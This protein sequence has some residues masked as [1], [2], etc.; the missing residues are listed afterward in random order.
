ML[1]KL[2]FSLVLAVSPLVSV[3][4]QAYQSVSAY[5]YTDFDTF[6]TE[7]DYLKDF[8]YVVEYG[9]RYG[10]LIGEIYFI[11]YPGEIY[12]YYAFPLNYDIEFKIGEFVILEPF[13]SNDIYKFYNIAV[14]Y[15]GERLVNVQFFNYIGNETEFYVLGLTSLS[16]SQV[17][18]NDYTHGYYDDPTIYGSFYKFFTGF[19]PEYVVVE[20]HGIF[21]FVIVA[22]LLFLVFGFVFFLFR[23]IRR[24]VGFK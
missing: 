4:N 6:Y 20:Y 21:T 10:E 22:F 12:Y 1:S 5:D 19:F 23:V 9:S 17:I 13:Y 7:Q 14:D 11:E 15:T 8:D 24:L 16:M 18:D 3:S 2:L